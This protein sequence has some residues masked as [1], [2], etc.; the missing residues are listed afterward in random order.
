MDKNKINIL[1]AE[2]DPNLGF[3]VKDTLESEGYK[4]TLCEDGISGIQ[5]FHQAKFDLCILDIMMPKKDGFALADDI[6]KSNELVPIIFLTAKSM[7][8]DVIKGFKKGADDYV[9]KPFSIEELLLRIEAI[10]KR[11]Y[12]TG[13]EQN[14]LAGRHGLFK[15]GSYEL[16][17]NNLILKSTSGEK[18]LTRKEAD[19]LRLLCINQNK[20]L[21]REMVLNIV[22]GNDDYFSGRSM[23]V[24]ISR[25]RKYLAEDPNLKITNVHG[26]GFRLD[27]D[28]D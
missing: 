8:E 26:E 16:D 21:T 10:L 18:T 7:K 22:W 11:T 1:L 3:V 13:K 15:I 19:V 9:I 12:S 4:V 14:L 27:I 5:A 2:D 17:H 6:R 25:L 24:F 23:D 20:L 28:S